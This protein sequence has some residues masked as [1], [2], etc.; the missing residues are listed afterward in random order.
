MK[1]QG[2][3]VKETAL[4]K[5]QKDFDQLDDL[6]GEISSCLITGSDLWLSYDEGAG[7]ERLSRSKNKDKYK[8]KSHKHYDLKD[9]FDLTDD[10][11]M[12]MEALAYA[13]P[14]LWFSGSMSLKRDQPDPEDSTEDQLKALTKIKVDANRF[15]LGCIP[16]LEEDGHFNLYQEASFLDHTVTAKMM[17][18]GATSSELHNALMADEHLADFMDIPSKDNGFDIEGMAVEDQRIFL[19]LRGPVLNGYA[20]ILEIIC[21]PLNGEL[22][23]QR[24]DGEA[25]L[26]RK[27][28]IDLSGMGI[29][30]LNID[31]KGDLYILAGPTMDLDGTISVYKIGGGLPDQEHSVT[32][33]PE[34][35]FDVAR[36]AEIK[37][38][39]DKAE[40]MAFIDDEHVLITYD[41]PI[42]ERLKSKHKVKMDVYEMSPKE[43]QS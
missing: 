34:R 15:S 10:S 3:D 30:E 21:E 38:G 9:F 14:Y 27:H 32:H 31:E 37:H 29:R 25:K 26:Y 5:F 19:G 13:P 43:N 4:L 23:M 8:Y 41:N 12:D 1:P 35:M 28:F 17:R 33:D 2:K 40:G 39:Y 20:L 7:I 36:G 11:E 42:E 6:R 16:C 22:I 24:R 18:G